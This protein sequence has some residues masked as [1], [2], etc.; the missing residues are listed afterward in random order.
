V[1]RALLQRPDFL[2]LDEAT[3]GLDDEETRRMYELLREQ[4]PGTALVSIAYRQALG[5]YHERHWRLAPGAVGNV[6]QAA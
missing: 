5:Q 1:A 4:L 2:F 3:S 6:L